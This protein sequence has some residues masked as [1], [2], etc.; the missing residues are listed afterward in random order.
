[1]TSR[2]SSTAPGG[3]CCG[4][5]RTIGIGSGRGDGPTRGTHHHVRRPCGMRSG[6][7]VERGVIDHRDSC[8]RHSSN[9]DPRSASEAAAHDGDG[10]ATRRRTVGRQNGGDSWRTDL[11]RHGVQMEGEA[12]IV[13]RDGQAL[14]GRTGSK[15]IVNANAIVIAVSV[16][17]HIHAVAARSKSLHTNSRRA[18]KANAVEG[19]GVVLAGSQ[20]IECDRCRVAVVDE[21]LRDQTAARAPQ[22][23]EIVAVAA[24]GVCVP[25]HIH[26]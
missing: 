24:E 25:S 5:S 9:R 18:I 2:R 17:I 11:Q 6:G 21:V 20:P 10:R 23:C 14:C 1:M 4:G 19:H 3:T 22:R 13:R 26:L 8:G 15:G 12:R 7:E 16:L